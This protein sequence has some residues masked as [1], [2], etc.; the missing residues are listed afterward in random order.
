MVAAYNNSYA[1]HLLMEA[2]AITRPSRISAINLGRC[3]T[4]RVINA[5]NGFPAFAR[6]DDSATGERGV[7]LQAAVA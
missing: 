4:D 2:G 6:I 1:W 5:E 3:S 7:S